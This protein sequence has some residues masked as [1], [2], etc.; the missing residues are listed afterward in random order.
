MEL[1]NFCNKPPWLECRGHISKGTWQ[2]SLWVCGFKS[3]LPWTHALCHISPLLPPDR[4]PRRQP[5]LREAQRRGCCHGRDHEM[6]HLRV[7]LCGP[8]RGR[9]SSA[10]AAHAG[11]SVPASSVPT[12]WVASRCPACLPVTT[13]AHD[14][15][16][17]CLPPESQWVCAE[18]TVPGT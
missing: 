18:S 5:C 10:W 7:T 6:E 1:G 9:Q 8:G 13:S 2:P 14:S 17:F 4:V 11:T 15:C 12:Q 16:V 3:L